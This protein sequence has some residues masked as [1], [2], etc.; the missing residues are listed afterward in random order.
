M[1]RR[2]RA[3]PTSVTDWCLNSKE[4]T[5]SSGWRWNRPSRPAWR[6]RR[7]ER[8]KK[9]LLGRGQQISCVGDV[10]QHLAARIFRVALL[11]GDVDAFV[12]SQWPVERDPG[13]KLRHAGQHAA[14][15]HLE[16]QMT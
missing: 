10:G 5:W 16:Q 6:L 12:K 15:N 3:E 14:M 1:A 8:S 11:D 4:Q 13:R 7:R 9:L 2:L